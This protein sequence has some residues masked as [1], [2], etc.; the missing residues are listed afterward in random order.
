VLTSSKGPGKALPMKPENRGGAVDLR[1]ASSLKNAWI[2]REREA[3]R[4]VGGERKFAFLVRREKPLWSGGG[5]KGEES[6]P[7]A[8]SHLTLTVPPG[9]EEKRGGDS[10]CVRSFNP[11]NSE[12]PLIIFKGREFSILKQRAA[13]EP[14][15]LRHQKKKEKKVPDGGW[16]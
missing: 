10:F 4:E 2:R 13:K 15:D 16:V 14:R 8:G 3:F 5:G 11:M 9:G 7:R 6:G 1:M 12:L